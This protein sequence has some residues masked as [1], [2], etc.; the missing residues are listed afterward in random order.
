MRNDSSAH[1]WRAAARL[2]GPDDDSKHLQLPPTHRSEASTRG[3][4]VLRRA[5]VK[6]NLPLDIDDEEAL[7]TNVK[8]NPQNEQR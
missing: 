6:R 4:T 7:S 2:L 1:A 5:Y 8:G 3:R